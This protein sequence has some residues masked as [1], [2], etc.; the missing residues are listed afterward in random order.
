MQNNFPLLCSSAP[1]TVATLCSDFLFIANSVAGCGCTLNSFGAWI[2]TCYY[3]N[4]NNL[5]IWMRSE[6]SFYSSSDLAYPAFQEDEISC[7][8]YFPVLS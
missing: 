2:D 1:T 5:K 8:V 4:K 3:K 6:T 7:V